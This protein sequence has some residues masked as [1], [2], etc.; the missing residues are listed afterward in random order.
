MEKTSDIIKIATRP[1]LTIEGL[2]L[3]F[4]LIVTGAD[5]PM[6]WD[7]FQITVVG[8][9]GWW[10]GQRQIGKFVEFVRNSK[11]SP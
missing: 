4:I 1:F 5:D 11:P 8:M 9:V 7:P 3:W 2:F 6:E 10:F